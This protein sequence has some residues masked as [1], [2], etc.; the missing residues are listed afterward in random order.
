MDLGLQNIPS[1]IASST[2]SYMVEFLPI[3]AIM[4][5]IA[6]AFVVGDYLIDLMHDAQSNAFYARKRSGNLT[7]DEQ[8]YYNNIN[9]RDFD[10]RASDLE[11]FYSRN[12]RSGSQYDLDDIRDRV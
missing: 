6:L 5:G 10:R 4:G 12:G 11:D 8:M 9:L 2:S 7:F 1:I 3:F